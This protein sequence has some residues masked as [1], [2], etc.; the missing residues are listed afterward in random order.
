M[1]DNAPSHASRLTLDLLKKSFVKN[2]TIM[3]R[4]EFI[5]HFSVVSWTFFICCNFCVAVH[6]EAS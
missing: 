4:I 5:A 3:E 6:L 1:Q 2:A